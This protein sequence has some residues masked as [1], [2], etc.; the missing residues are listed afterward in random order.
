MLL[1]KNWHWGILIFYWNDFKTRNNTVTIVLGKHLHFSSRSIIHLFCTTISHMHTSTYNL[2][3][4]SCC[5]ALEKERL[6]LGPASVA[7]FICR[8]ECMFSSTRFFFSCSCTPMR[9]RLYW[10]WFTGI[11]S[12]DMLKSTTLHRWL[13]F[14]VDLDGICK[15]IFSAAEYPCCIFDSRSLC[16]CPLQLM[17]NLVRTITNFLKQDSVLTNSAGVTE[18]S[19]TCLLWRMRLRGGG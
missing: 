2:V 11:V 17:E 6:V 8:W 18:L 14:A 3:L 1:I 16:S 9:L 5:N 4:L 7:F 12:R 10:Y 13:S 19:D 15:E